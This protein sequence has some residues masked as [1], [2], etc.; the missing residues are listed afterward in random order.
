MRGFLAQAYARAEA[1]YRKVFERASNGIEIADKIQRAAANVL[2]EIARDEP[3]TRIFLSRFTPER[4]AGPD[5]GQALLA[6]QAGTAAPPA[7]LPTKTAGR[8][9][10]RPVG[11]QHFRA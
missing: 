2:T 3:Q 9:A 4:L 6:N 1:C 5:P 8:L 7:T 10:N 11:A